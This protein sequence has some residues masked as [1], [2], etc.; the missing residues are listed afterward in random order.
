LK[1][2][3]HDSFN[4]FLSGKGRNF[5]QESQA[6][7]HLLHSVGG[8]TIT[9]RSVGFALCSIQFIPWKIQMNVDGS[10]LDAIMLA[11]FTQLNYP[12]SPSK[13]LVLPEN[14]VK[15]VK[16]GSDFKTREVK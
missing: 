5:H 12:V 15:K 2:I 16:P 13:Y 3:G 4:E 6:V 10:A 7:K 14:R 9:I 11:T 8:A 1:F